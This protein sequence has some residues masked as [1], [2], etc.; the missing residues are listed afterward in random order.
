MFH[1]RGAKNEATHYADI[2]TCPTGSLSMRCLGLHIAEKEQETNI[3]RIL[4]IKWKRNVVAPVNGSRVTLI[5]YPLNGIPNLMMSF[6][7][8]ILEVNKKIGFFYSEDFMAG[9]IQ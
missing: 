5:Q 8:L 6:Y 1:F 2:L 7:G 3:G 9:R 4:R